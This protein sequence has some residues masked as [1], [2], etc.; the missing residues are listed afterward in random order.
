MVSI[1]KAEDAMF[2]GKEDLKSHFLW[3]SDVKV[4]DDAEVSGGQC[5]NPTSLDHE[6][7]VVLHLE[8]R[9]LGYHLYQPIKQQEQSENC[10]YVLTYFHCW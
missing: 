3:V 10:H 5:C 1:I 9:I 4:A 7:R 2:R 8:V 6:A